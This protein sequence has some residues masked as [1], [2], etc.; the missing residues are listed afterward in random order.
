MRDASTTPFW[1][2]RP[3]P[4]EAAP[5]GG[6]IEADL[7]IVGGGFTGLWAALHAFGAARRALARAAMGASVRPVRPHRS[8]RP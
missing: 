6:A 4:A 3:R 2:D 7:A 5:L 1:L 8:R